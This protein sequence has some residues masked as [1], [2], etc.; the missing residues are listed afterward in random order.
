MPNGGIAARPE[1]VGAGNHHRLKPGRYL[2]PS[3]TDTGKGMNEASGRAEEA[4]TSGFLVDDY[5][6][7][8]FR[9]MDFFLCCLHIIDSFTQLDVVLGS[10]GKLGE[11]S[12][13]MFDFFLSHVLQ[14]EECVAGAFTD[15]DQLI[16]LEMQRRHIAVLRVLNQKH[17]EKSDDRC[18]CIDDELPSIGESENGVGDRPNH[19]RGAGDGEGGGSTAL[20]GCPL[21]C[22]SES[23]SDGKRF[24]FEIL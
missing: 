13:K 19:Y 15:P 20:L 10:T 8:L 12:F 18:A 5:R 17:H 9:L 7:H 11:T 1:I 24:G 23:R 22:G 2:C 4:Q 6:D 16:E 3:V 21:N 14:I